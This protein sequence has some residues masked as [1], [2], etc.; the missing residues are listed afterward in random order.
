[1]SRYPNVVPGYSDHTIGIEAATYAVA[2][3]ARIIEKH[4]TLDNNY[5]DF[6]D[7]QLSANPA[8][9]HNMVN[10]IRSLEKTMGAGVINPQLCEKESRV[11]LRRSIVAASELPKHTKLTSK[12]LTW[13]RPGNG[14]APGNES[15][16]LGRTLGRSIVQGETIQVDDLIP[17]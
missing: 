5:S 15:I 1:M 16:L 11:A 4:F 12:H 9:F 6:R 8:D 10:R 13:V 7:H 3:G 17:L 2:R 14:L